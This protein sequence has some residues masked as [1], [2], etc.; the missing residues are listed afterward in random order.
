MNLNTLFKSH[1][2][3]ARYEPSPLEIHAGEPALE[4]LAYIEKKLGIEPP[5]P[6]IAMKISGAVG[7]ENLVVIAEPEGEL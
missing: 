2:L 6:E 4:R 3:R 7:A 5:P 1:G